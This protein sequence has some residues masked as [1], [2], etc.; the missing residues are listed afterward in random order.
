MWLRPNCQREQCSLHPL[1][2][3]SEED[4]Q[5]REEQA[6][7]LKEREMPRGRGMN[8]QC[9]RGQHAFVEA[10]RAT[11]YE[12]GTKSEL[13]VQP[14]RCARGGCGATATRR[15]GRDGQWSRWMK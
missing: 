15:K 11:V 10:G 5:D 9:A 7:Q 1:P 8:E 6:Q 14:G 13:T 3:G 2:E 12:K 4:H